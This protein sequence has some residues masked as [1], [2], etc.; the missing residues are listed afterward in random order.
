[1]SK[2][3]SVSVFAPSKINLFLHVGAKRADGYHDICSLAAFADVGDRLDGKR[4]GDLTLAISGRLAEGLSNGEDNL[5]VR[6][7]RALEAW[8]RANARKIDGAQLQLEKN[9]PLASGIGGGS[10]DA[11][12]TLTLLNKLW[13]L[14]ASGA[15]LEAIGAT[16]GA[17]VPVC[18]RGSATLMQG[19]GEKLTPWPSL[20]PLPIVLVNPGISVMTAHVF[21]ALE[22]RSGTDAPALIE[23]KSVGEIAAWMASRRNDLEAPARRIAPVIGE[24]LAE[25]SA[26]PGCL[27][28]RMS[29][30]GATCFGIYETGGAASAAAAALSSHH[31]HWWIATSTLR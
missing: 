1:M 23:F 25:I 6:A 7:A 3:N 30:S 28:A 15:D 21:R 18:L 2:Y 12:A 11:A 16:L 4:A 13:R 24:V 5:V 27:V 17:D 26:T 20:P 9:V 31:P 22:A 14:N 19:I 8:G 10:S 29:G